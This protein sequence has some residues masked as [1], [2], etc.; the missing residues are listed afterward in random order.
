MFAFVKERRSIRSMIFKV[1]DITVG[2][3]PSRR[4]INIVNPTLRTLSIDNDINDNI[5]NISIVRINASL[6]DS[7]L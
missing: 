6:E 1:L 7:Q 5:D 3:K 4:S 2:E